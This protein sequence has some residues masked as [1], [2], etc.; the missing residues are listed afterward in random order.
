M[1][2][3]AKESGCENAKKLAAR[4][5]LHGAGD[6]PEHLESVLMYIRK[7]QLLFRVSWKRRPLGVNHAE[8]PQRR[9]IMPS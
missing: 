2:R 9:P 3:H 7:N 6:R 1:P 4:G 5:S 8:T